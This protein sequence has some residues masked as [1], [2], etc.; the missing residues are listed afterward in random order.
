MG[1]VVV[2]R[3][4]LLLCSCIVL[5]ATS[6]AQDGWSADPLA[7]RFAG[8]Y[9]QVEVGGPYAGAEFHNSLPLP[10]RISFFY[11][12]ANSIDLSTD[13]WKRADS[14]PLGI[15]IEIDKQGARAIGEEPWEYSLSPH[16]VTF[17]R[18]DDSLACTIYYEFGLREP[19]MIFRLTVMNRMPVRKL[20]A[21]SIHLSAVLRSCQTYARFDNPV[22][23][24]DTAGAATIAR[25]SEPQTAG[26][27]LF[28]CNVGEESGSP[29][30]DDSSAATTK[31][32]GFKYRRELE[33]PRLH[34]Y[35]ASHWYLQEQ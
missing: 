5:A 4:I 28:V 26:T 2:N 1:M 3:Q 7:Y 10:S 27:S 25:F 29:V 23:I 33:Q 17:R 19:V 9:G 31:L 20:I 18:E 24:C 35:R 13:Y 6:S 14:H 32:C 30:M 11:P 8:R 16:K 15:D 34:V 21:P 12:V 22:M